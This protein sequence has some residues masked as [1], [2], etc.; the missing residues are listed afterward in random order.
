MGQVTLR[1]LST[2]E[3]IVI[4]PEG[5]IFGRVGGDADIQLEDNS[6]SRRQARVSQK[7]GM[8]LLETLAVPQGSKAPRPVQLQE[9]ASFAVGQS[10]FEV[11]QIEEDEEE[12]AAPT[13]APTKGKPGPAPVS[14]QPAGKKPNAPPN[15]KTVPSASQQKRPDAPKAEEPAA[16][17]KGGIGAMFVGVPK[18][19][20]Y[21][22]LNVPKLL[23]NPVG[24]VRKTIEELPTE[25]LGKT[26]IIGYSVPAIFIAGA[27]PSI[28]GGIAGL[29]GPGHVFSLMAFLPIPAAVSAIIGALING[30]FFHRIAEWVITKL[31]GKSDARSRSN[32]FLHL[33]TVTIIVAVPNALGTILAAL[34]IPFINLL[35]PL[36]MVVGSLASLYVM[37][38]W[39]VKFEVVKWVL[40]VIKVLAV[41]SLLGTGYGFVT[42][43]INTIRGFGSGGGSSPAAVDTGSSELGEMPTDPAEAAEWSKRK[44]EELEA[45]QKKA[46]AA[47]D[48][49]KDDAEDA[50]PEPVKAAKKDDP[51]AAKPEKAEKPEKPEKAEATP[52][53]PVKDIAPAPKDTPPAPTKDDSVASPSSGYATFAKRRD[54]IEKLLEAD[55]TVLKKNS[56]VRELYGDYVEFAYDLDKKMQADN[57]K[58]PE[59]AKLN[60]RLRDAELYEKSGKTIDSLAAKLGIK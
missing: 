9:G 52:P 24:S 45:A 54:A 47:A 7:G 6:I 23:V 15:A 37:Y 57:K 20:A 51:P 27:L 4:P 49:T 21:Y 58:K 40:L 14:A 41:L 55:P 1:D 32:Y 38:Q 28:A 30:F 12:P 39:M 11:V 25:P 33:M 19:I 5:F 18:G 35:G 42:G 8:W 2:N 59:R 44:Q 31:K 29:I 56:E 10:E 3:D 50:K 22:L 26:E 53:P 48:D 46:Q 16:E 36:L 60:A 13:L 17:G 43:L 34:P